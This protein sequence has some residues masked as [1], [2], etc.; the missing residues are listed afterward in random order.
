MHYRLPRSRTRSY[1]NSFW[2]GVLAQESSLLEACS[3]F[4]VAT[5]RARSKFVSPA[6]GL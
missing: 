2:L 3:I 6:G 5:A 1:K 4:V